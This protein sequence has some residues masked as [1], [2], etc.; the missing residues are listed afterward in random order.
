M[1]RWTESCPLEGLCPECGLRFE[2]R[3]VFTVPPVPRWWIE[4]GDAPLRQRV[5][6][7][8]LRSTWPSAFWKKVR[9]EFGGNLFLSFTLLALVLGCFYLL[10]VAG[11]IALLVNFKLQAIPNGLAP[12]DWRIA[13]V[14]FNSLRTASIV[15]LLVFA[16]GFPL[17]ATVLPQTRHRAKVAWSHLFR[18]FIYAT[19]AGLIVVLVMSAAYLLLKFAEPEAKSIF[20]LN[21]FIGLLLMLS[22]LGLPAFVLLVVLSWFQACRH[23]LKLEH[24]PAVAAS[25]T[26]ISGLFV[27]TAIICI[28]VV[29]RF[30]FYSTF[31]GP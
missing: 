5:L 6:Q 30:G 1:V 13:F 29:Q 17:T 27:I 12:S 15:W 3:H 14:P 23:Y 8:L 11:R 25:L 18:V 28:D 22:R 24:A 16:A 7:S 10:G 21:F 26:L 20:P 9:L 19:A 2:W 31:F 4:D